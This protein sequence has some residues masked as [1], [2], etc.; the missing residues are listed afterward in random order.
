MSSNPGQGKQLKLF[1][2]ISSLTIIF[3]II[4]RLFCS[5]LILIGDKP[6]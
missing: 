6:R 1:Q 2:G 3:T 4:I 5:L